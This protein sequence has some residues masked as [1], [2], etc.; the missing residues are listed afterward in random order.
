VAASARC[1][2]TIGAGAELGTLSGPPFYAE[3][4]AAPA[5]LITDIGAICAPLSWHHGRL[6]RTFALTRRN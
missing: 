1:P 6:F 5:T 3:P 2:A 4:T